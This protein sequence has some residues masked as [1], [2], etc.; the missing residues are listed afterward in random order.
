[1]DIYSKISKKPLI[2]KRITGISIQQFTYIKEKLKPLFHKKYVKKKK[3]SGRPYGISSI[4]NQLLCLLIYY[5]TYT[6]QLFIGFQFN[7]DDATVSRTIRRLEP[8]VAK[9]VQI[10]KERK[11]SQEDLETLIIDCTEQPIRRPKR[12]QK[13]YYSGK[14]KRHTM[15]TEIVMNKKGR[16]CK[17]SK[18]R[19]GNVHDI[20]IRR[21][22]GP[23]PPC[24]EILADSG[25]QGLQ[26]EYP[27]I[28]LPIKKTRGEPLDKKSKRKNKKLS[29][30][31]VIV[32]NKIGEMKIFQIFAQVYRNIRRSYGLKARIVAGLVNLKNGF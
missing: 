4:E 17:I 21:K 20:K 25:Y 9:I 16:I 23:L 28:R 24:K 22:E 8:L 2:F 7:V 32:E 3:V 11:I 19:P 13:R 14:K 29:K 5:R 6:T 18:P 1:M 15:K 27:Q 12:G 10:K 26:N 31:R 30:E